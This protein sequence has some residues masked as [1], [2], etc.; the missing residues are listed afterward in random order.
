MFTF[1]DTTGKLP[2]PIKLLEISPNA[3]STNSV[4][5]KLCTGSTFSLSF[6]SVGEYTAANS[7]TAQ[8][9]DKNGSFS[10]PVTIRKFYSRYPGTI[11]CKI[12]LNTIPGDGYRVRVISNHLSTI[13]TDNGSDIIISNASPT[14]AITSV[15][16]FCRPSSNNLFE[17]IV[18]QNGISYN[19][20]FP[21]GATIN[22]GLGTDSVVVSFGV[23]ASAGNVCLAVSNGCGSATVCNPVASTNALPPT[24]GSIIGLNNGCL[25][26]SLIY[27]L[28]KVNHT[29]NYLWTPPAGAT[30]N[31][32]S[33]P[34]LT[35]DTMIKIAFSSGFTGDTLRVRS[36][37]CLGNSISDRFLK[38][39]N[40]SPS[41]QGLI[42]GQKIG[43]CNQNNI[44]YNINPVNIA[45]NYTWRTDIANATINGSIAPV[46]TT[47][48][49]TAD[50]GTFVSGQI[51]VKANNNCGSSA[52]RNLT[53]NAKPAVPSIINGQSSVCDGDTGLFSTIAVTNASA[54]NWT[55]LSGSSII[56]GQG[57]ISAR[58]KFGS[59]ATSGVVRVRSQNSCASSAY[60]TKTVTVNLCPRMMEET[61]NDQLT[62]YPNPFSATTTLVIPEET[63]L[64]NSQ[65]I[66]YDVFGKEI[67][68][69]NPEY[70]S[71]QIEKGNLSQGIYIVKLISDERT[72]GSVKMIVE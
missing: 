67:K 42:S 11:N 59:V 29:D 26:D 7:F 50:F 5:S 6:M 15:S 64:N 56:N 58:I 69:I 45:L 32:S 34:V 71:I 1:N 9:S 16:G 57:T 63:D 8:L 12:P 22:S 36:V 66:V 10:S 46:S 39:N 35:P 54:Y 43:L 19:W 31:G 60:L 17:A 55:T 24:P 18:P 20:S 65:I 27:Y 30:I 23:N 14:P 49:I 47:N 25:G 51:F 33:F 38:I 48:S 62:I 41:I 21:P 28:N 3:I 68:T 40:N 44:I 4:A 52:E 72:S 61:K 70:Y 37:N 13:G 2:Y 53:I